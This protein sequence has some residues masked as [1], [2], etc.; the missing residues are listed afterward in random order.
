M[1]NLIQS[2][3]FEL[4]KDYIKSKAIKEFNLKKIHLKLFS[5]FSKNTQRNNTMLQ[6][7]SFQRELVML[8]ETVLSK[9][10]IFHR[11]LLLRI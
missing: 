6:L 7:H 4:F 5:F 9:D 2:N 8:H 11:R 3:H 10:R 1:S